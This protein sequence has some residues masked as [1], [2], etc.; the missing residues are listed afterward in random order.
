MSTGVKMPD[1]L[2]GEGQILDRSIA[3]SGEEQEVEPSF[4]IFPSDFF[5]QSGRRTDISHDE[6]EAGDGQRCNLC[7]LLFAAQG[8]RGSCFTRTQWGAAVGSG[9]LF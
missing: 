1:Y 3:G 4:K 2:P 9:S 8:S 5:F 7:G 6:E